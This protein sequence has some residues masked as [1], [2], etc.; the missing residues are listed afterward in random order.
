[1]FNKKEYNHQWYLQNREKSIERATKWGQRNRLRRA[2]LA[3]EYYR[4][5]R[6]QRILHDREYYAKHR[7]ELLERKKQYAD[8][9]SE[10]RLAKT[11]AQ[12]IPLGSQ[13]EQCGATENLEHHHPNYAMPLHVITLCRSCHATIHL[14]LKKEELKI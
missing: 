4:R 8:Q 5:H 14:G 6:T 2:T 3:R 7:E 11:K 1:M 12:Y 13:C 10:K 9:N